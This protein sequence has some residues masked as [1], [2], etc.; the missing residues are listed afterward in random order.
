MS[1]W[2]CTVCGHIQHKGSP[3]EKCPVCKASGEKFIEVEDSS[4]ELPTGESDKNGLKKFRCTV[5]GYL[6]IGSEPPEK[7]PVCHAP[8]LMF[9]E[10]VDTEEKDA[11]QNSGD[12]DGGQ[13][14]KWYCNVCGYKHRGTEPP[15]RCPVCGAGKSSFV[16][17]GENGRPAGDEDGLVADSGSSERSEQQAESG[18]GEKK[19]FFMLNLFSRLVLRF[20][21]HPISVHFPNGILPAAV[22]FLGLA[23]YFKNGALETVAYYNLIF[24]LITLPLVLLSGYL[25]WQKRYRG[26]KS[27]VFIVKIFCAILVV[28]SVLVLVFW[29][30]FDPAVLAEG[31]P[32][33]LYYLGLAGV[34]VGAAAISGHLG[35]RL[36]FGSRA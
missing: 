5:C 17:F 28:L 20:H 15:D 22:V 21:L 32:Y 23:F 26:I 8:A 16:R 9:E 7:C 24:V 10:I 2:E 31:S 13:D 1:N 6:H 34:M 29:R 30:L 19:S 25:E 11:P 33:R 4:K 12:N 3:P 27:T 36:V 18:G 35:G 14:E